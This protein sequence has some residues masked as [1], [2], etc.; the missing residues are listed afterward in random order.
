MQ[1]MFWHDSDGVLKFADATLGTI[2]ENLK[3]NKVKI[4]WLL[5]PQG[6]SRVKVRTGGW[7]KHPLTTNQVPSEILLSNMLME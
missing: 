4:V 1:R 3:A 5:Q 2:A 6:W 7:E